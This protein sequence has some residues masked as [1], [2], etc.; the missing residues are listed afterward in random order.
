MADLTQAIS[1]DLLDG[2]YQ[3]QHQF[4]VGKLISEYT[5]K[6]FDEEFTQYYNVK[7]GK[8]AAAYTGPQDVNDFAWYIF[9]FKNGSNPV[10]TTNAVQERDINMCR[11]SLFYHKVNFQFPQLVLAYDTYFAGFSSGAFCVFP[12]YNIPLAHTASRTQSATFCYCDELGNCYF[13]PICRPYFNK[14]KAHPNQVYIDNLYL[15]AQGNAV[16]FPLV[17][18]VLDKEG[19]F[20]GVFGANMIPSYTTTIATGQTSNNY[21]SDMYLGGTNKANYVV[22]DNQDIVSRSYVKYNSGAQTGVRCYLANMCSKSQI[23]KKRHQLMIL[24]YST[25]SKRD[26]RRLHISPGMRQNSM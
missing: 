16:G 24:K 19:N 25:C 1:L 18:P 21:I 12:L 26:I 10:Y 7:V 8:D 4:G 20:Q 13:N 9:P 11:N 22:A 23:S 14:A 6:H 5:E 2:F 3:A 15:F 17:A